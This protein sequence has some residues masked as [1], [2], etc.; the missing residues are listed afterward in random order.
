MYHCADALLY[1]HSCNFLH[2]DL[3]GD[4]VIISGNK[5]N[6]YPVI[7]DFGK[8]TETSKGKFYKLSVRDQDNYRKYHK[9]IAPEVVRGTQSQAIDVYAFGLLLSFLCKYKQF[10]PLQKLAVVCIKGN[11]EKRP[12]TAQLVSRLQALHLSE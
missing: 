7:I 4:N 12:T 2:N 11:P 8:S 5:N 9:H 1:I 6:F 10:E 3:K